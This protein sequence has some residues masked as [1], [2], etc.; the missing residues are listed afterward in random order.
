[1]PDSHLKRLAKEDQVHEP[2]L[3]LNVTVPTNAV[4][5]YAELYASGNNEEEFWVR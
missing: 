1:M 4:A 5:A 3:Q 2:Y